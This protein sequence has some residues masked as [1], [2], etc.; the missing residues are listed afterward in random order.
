MDGA[1]S[2]SQFLGHGQKIGGVLALSSDEVQTFDSHGIPSGGSAPVRADRRKLGT[3]SAMG[4]T[5]L[6]KAIATSRPALA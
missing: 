3:G 2:I 5:A 1:F 4:R 6:L